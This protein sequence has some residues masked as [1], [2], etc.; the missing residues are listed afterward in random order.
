MKTKSWISHKQDGLTGSSERCVYGDPFS[1][2]PTRKTDGEEYLQ[3][4]HTEQ[5]DDEEERPSNTCRGRQREGPEGA[6]PS[7]L[8]PVPGPLSHRTPS[9]P[10]G[11]RQHP[12]ARLSARSTRIP[13]VVF[14]R[15][16]IRG[17]RLMAQPACVY[18]RLYINITCV[19]LSR[20]N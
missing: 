5:G 7:Q 1:L 17:H 19:L 3:N 11:P 16:V 12:N 15:H 10:V 9:G 2:H 14:N 18:G 4:K 6:R 13:S 20:Q 8:H